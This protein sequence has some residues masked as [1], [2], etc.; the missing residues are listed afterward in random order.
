MNLRSTRSFASTARSVGRSTG[1]E[2]PFQRWSYKFSA[3]MIKIPGTLNADLQSR[4]CKIGASLR[5]CRRLRCHRA[6]HDP[7]DGAA[8]DLDQIPDHE[9]VRGLAVGEHPEHATLTLES[10]LLSKRR[11]KDCQGHDL[12]KVQLLD[13]QPGTTLVPDLLSSTDELV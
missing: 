10:R 4:P 2:L 13:E 5:Q 3:S 8:L 1:T 7:Q 6:A 11:I 9:T 12:F